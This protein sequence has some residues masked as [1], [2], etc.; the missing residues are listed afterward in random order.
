MPE[1]FSGIFHTKFLRISLEYFYGN[2]VKFL[3]LGHHVYG[4]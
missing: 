2:P 4:F 1:N 3:G